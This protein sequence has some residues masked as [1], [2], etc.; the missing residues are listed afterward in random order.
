MVYGDG[1]TDDVVRPDARSLRALTHPLR[2]R[3]LGLLR[4]EG[5]ATATRLAA[6]TGESTGSTSYHLRR[7]AADGFVVED[8]DRGSARDRWWRAAHRSTEFDVPRDS[9]AEV[10]EEALALGEQY[11]RVVA[12]GLHERVVDAVGRLATLDDDLGEGWSQAFTMSDYALRLTREEAAGLVAALEAL[13]VRHR[14]DDPERRTE[15]PDGSERVLLQF[16]VLPQLPV[17]PTTQEES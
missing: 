1:M 8:A 9:P 13:A 5:P 16:Q 17:R 11:L 4:A 15:A 12:G 14:Q 6:L 3:L 10:R 2:L 7:L